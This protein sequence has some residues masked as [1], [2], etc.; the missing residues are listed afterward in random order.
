MRDISN[1]L[2]AVESLAPSA[3]TATING[4]GVDLSGFNGA[5]VAWSFG[6]WT[7][8]THTPSV[9]E[10]SDNTT[11]T[12]VAAG[13]LEGSFNPVSSGAGANMVQKVGYLGNLRYIRAVLTVAGAT[14]GA[15]S[16]V[17]VIR[18]FPATAPTV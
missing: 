1:N 8:G 14:S 17:L 11:F 6:S 12:A 7:D 16:S 2:S 9:Q 5:M 15:V 3:R 4:A 13:D 10:S 18:G